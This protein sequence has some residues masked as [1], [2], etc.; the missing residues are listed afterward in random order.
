MPKKYTITSLTLLILLVLSGGQVFYSQA[1]PLPLATSS[2]VID[3]AVWEAIATSPTREVTVAVSLRPEGGGGP[4]QAIDAQFRLE[5]ALALL[6]EAG[7]A[8]EM[9]AFYGANVIKISGGLGVL[10]L[11]EDWPELESVSLYEPGETWELQADSA[12]RS[13]EINASGLIIGKVTAANGGT[14]LAGMR[15]RAYRLVEGVTWEVAGTTLTN[16]SGDYAV[17]GLASGIYRAEFE[18]PAG[19]YA[20]QFFDNKVS[21]TLATNFSVTDGQVTPNINA[22]MAL[23]GKISGTVT[24]VGGGELK[25]IV[26]RAATDAGGSWQ[27]VSSTVSGSNGTYTIGSLPPGTYRVRFADIHTPPSYVVQWYDGQLAVEDAQDIS[28]TAGSTVT[29]INAVMGSYGSITGNVKADDGVTNLSGIYVDVYRFD[30]T[31][32]AWDWFASDS[33]NTA[34]NYEVF[35]LTTENY[36][37][38]FIDPLD[39]YFSQ[40]YN[41]K[42]NIETADNVAVTLGFPTTGIDARLATKAN[43]SIVTST[44]GEDAKEPTGPYIPVGEQVE[45]TYEITSL[46]QAYIFTEI[47]VTDDSGVQVTCPTTTLGPEDDPIICT[48][49]ST[50]QLGQQSLVAHV[51]AKVTPLSTGVELGMVQ[52]S[53]A[54]HYFGY[55]LG[56]DLVKR[57]NG[58][59]VPEPPGPQLAVGGTVTWTYEVTNVS[60]VPLT[61][62]ELI[63]EPEGTIN[64]PMTTLSAA[65]VMTC[66]ATGIV[67]QGQYQNLAYASGMFGQDMVES[68]VAVSYYLG[69]TGF[70]IFL[71]L[72][73][74]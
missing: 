41:N 37:V 64:C 6:T 68:Y 65:E 59:V 62:I 10:R 23:A 55:T 32:N 63:D 29:G 71:P 52:A 60:N 34:G 38:E 22:A 69:T 18:D 70:F 35:G 58:Q 17:S 66:V 8:R 9:R 2:S 31:L 45:F 36:R 5:K 25:D 1:A 12:L 44:N 30:S 51:S 43:I 72:I 50:A 3:T 49:A 48:A 24:E 21:F 40:F 28:V 54:S 20:K 74:R 13:E 46:E 47:E 39:R 26:V 67:I 53:D 33:T 57:T 14:P 15:V 61:D 16:E 4:E 11:L 73:M 42:P 27:Y 56:L 19:N 7:E